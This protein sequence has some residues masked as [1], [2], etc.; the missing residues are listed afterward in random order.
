VRACDSYAIARLRANQEF[1]VSDLLTSSDWY[2]NGQWDASHSQD[3]GSVREYWHAHGRPSDARELVTAWWRAQWSEDLIADWVDQQ[4]V[5]D[6]SAFGPREAWEAW[7][8]G[9]VAYAIR[10]TAPDILEW[11]EELHDE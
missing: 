11:I 10:C 6:E 4:F 3:P 7:S 1:P 5:P 8:R 9:W 2:K